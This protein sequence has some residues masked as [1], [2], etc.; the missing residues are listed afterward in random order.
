MQSEYKKVKTEKGRGENATD[1][2]VELLPALPANWKEGEITG[3]RARGGITVNMRW[4]D[5]KVVKLS[6]KAQQA[7]K[8]TLI[9]NGKTKKIKLKKGDNLIKTI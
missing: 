6:L 8:I 5:S 1:V 4:S 9:C 2:T 7:C 3:I